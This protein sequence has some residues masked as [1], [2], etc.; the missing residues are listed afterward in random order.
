MDGVLVMPVEGALVL[1]SIVPMKFIMQ[2]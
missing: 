1:V 2:C